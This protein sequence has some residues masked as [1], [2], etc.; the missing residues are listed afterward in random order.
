MH[1]THR[2]ELLAGPVVSA[3]QTLSAGLDLWESFEPA[4]SERTFVF[5][6]TDYTAFALLPA[7]MAQLQRQA[8]AVKLRVVHSDQKVSIEDLAAG[9]IDFALGYGE[10]RDALPGGV[11]TLDWFH[12]EYVVIASARHP[13]VGRRLD[14]AGFLAERHVIATPWNEE[15]GVIDRVLDGLGLERRVALQLPSV[16][17]APFVV[18]DSELLMT[19]PRH[20]AEL[21]CRSAPVSLHPAPFAIPP[22]V[23]KLYSHGKYANSDAHGWMRAQILA[24][25]PP[26]PDAGNAPRRLKRRV[27]P[28]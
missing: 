18:A 17:A 11:Q 26:A 23:L 7:L 12:G 8:P 9:R 2:A 4:L 14:L 22:Y 25:H 6:A 21:L 20:A 16:L 5:S 19:L 24:L 1:P 15:R 13:R 27:P 3:L 10:E 28:Q